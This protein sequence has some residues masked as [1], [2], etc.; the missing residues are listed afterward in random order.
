MCLFA[1]AQRHG[2]GAS[3][4]MLTGHEGTAMII[5]ERTTV[6]DVAS[7]LPSS[8]RIFQRYNIDFCCG[9]KTPLAAACQA[10]GVSYDELVGA[11]DASARQPAPDA[12]DWSR[13]P[14]HALIDH[15]VSS[16]H[17]PLREELPRLEGLA[18]K[19]HRVHG[20]KAAHLSRVEAIVSELSADLRSHMQKEEAVLFPAIRSADAEGGHPSIPLPAAV[21]VM[22]AEHDHAGALL[23]ELRTVTG[24]YAAPDWACQ[25]FRALYHGL[26]ELEAAMHVHVHL[27]NN[28]L[29][30]RAV[31]AQTPHPVA[32]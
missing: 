18:A 2:P 5:T 31:A 29:F 14:S 26:A 1:R 24:D 4:I 13:E 16:Y 12:R 6:A 17:D 22:E 25:T 10:Q 7:A 9:G 27:E 15:I 30:P 8:I 20:S 23:S 19:V 28:I 11:I 21:T 32:G 3:L